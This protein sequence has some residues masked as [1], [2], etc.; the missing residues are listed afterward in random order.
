MA[1]GRTLQK[2]VNNKAAMIR[3]GG[4]LLGE[5]QGIV[6]G[7]WEPMDAVAWAAL[8]AGAT[9]DGA[10]NDIEF[11]A[12]PELVRWQDMELPAPMS[13]PPENNTLYFYPLPT[14]A[15]YFG[16]CKWTGDAWNL[17]MLHGGWAF[18]SRKAAQTV[19]RALYAVWRAA[20][21]AEVGQSKR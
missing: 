6:W 17:H 3:R 9:N 5:Q 13:T 21:K 10:G 14:T 12:V 18:D 8:V 19:G 20:V 4:M 11:R 7:A 15:D 1:D 16:R 2:R